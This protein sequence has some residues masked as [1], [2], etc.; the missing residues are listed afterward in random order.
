MSSIA[1]GR[2][3]KVHAEQPAAKPQDEAEEKDRIVTTAEEIEGRVLD[4]IKAANTVS[5]LTDLLPMTVIATEQGI[6]REDFADAKRL[7]LE[8]PAAVA[9]IVKGWVNGEAPA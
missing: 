6:A 9:N 4:R 1:T 5:A 3:S 2:T 8:N 7:A